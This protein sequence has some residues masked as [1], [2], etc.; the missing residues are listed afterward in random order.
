MKSNKA[1]QI[2]NK[3]FSLY[4]FIFYTIIRYN[5]G[6]KHFLNNSLKLKSNSHI[7]D[8]GCGS[9]LLTKTLY[10]QSKKYNLKN[11]KFTAIDISQKMLEPFKAWIKNNNITNIKI[12]QED[13]LNLKE[14]HKPNTYDLIVSSAML[15]Y[16]SKQELKQTLSNFNQTLKKQ[17]KILIFISKKNTIT[18]LL[19]KKWWKANTHKKQEIKSLLI[20][21]SFK[22]INFKKFKF[23]YNYLNLGIII[24]QATK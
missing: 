6:V 5:K 3:K 4:H 19:I 8:A 18:N 17:G 22:N 23:P 16:L 10:S 11:I 15:E 21:Q 20:K 13:I 14:N 24:V 12:N 2:Y 7:L 9:G 1:K